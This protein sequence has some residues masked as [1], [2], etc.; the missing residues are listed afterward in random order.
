[1]H[2]GAVLTEI[3]GTLVKRDLEVERAVWRGELSGSGVT[4]LSEGGYNN[5]K[6]T[7]HIYEIQENK[8]K[9]VNVK[10]DEKIS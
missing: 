2:T 3:S 4:E 7:V 10:K 9:I 6:N 1:M 5:V 8:L